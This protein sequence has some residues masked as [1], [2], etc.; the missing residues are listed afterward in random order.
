M[1]A[2]QELFSEDI[3]RERQER[4]RCARIRALT[5]PPTDELR[6]MVEQ[7]RPKPMAATP[8]RGRDAPVRAHAGSVGRR[9]TDRG[10]RTT[11]PARERSPARSPT[12]APGRAVPRRFSPRRSRRGEPEL[13]GSNTTAATAC[14]S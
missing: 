5:M 11:S 14:S 10:D 12:P 1:S 3:V 7:H 9:A 2:L 13:T 6:L 4:Q 8:R